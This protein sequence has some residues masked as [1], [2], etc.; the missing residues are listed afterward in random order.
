MATLCSTRPSASSP[1]AG[2]SELPMCTAPL[3]TCCRPLYE[4]PPLTLTVT[5]RCSSMKISA[6]SEARGRSAVEPLA[7]MVPASGSLGSAFGR[8][9][10]PERTSAA[11]SSMA[12]SARLRSTAMSFRHLFS[13]DQQAIFTVAYRY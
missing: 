9:P 10:Q 8:L 5:F 2:M 3:A 6:A 11:R 4:P 13:C 12:R 7:V 1:V